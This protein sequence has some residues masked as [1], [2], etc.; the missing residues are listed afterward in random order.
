[1]R[2]ADE[3]YPVAYHSRKFNP[4]ECNYSTTDRE[5]LSIV[6]SLRHFRH[7]LLGREFRVSTDHKPLIYYFGKSRQLSSREANW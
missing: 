6:D 7:C 4:T 1:M 3:L 2:D 5:M